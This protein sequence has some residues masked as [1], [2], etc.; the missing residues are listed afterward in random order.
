MIGSGGGGPS[1]CPQ[2]S[3][4]RMQKSPIRYKG[5][6]VCCFQ[7][8]KR[9]LS[10]SMVSLSVETALGSFDFLNNSDWEEEDEENG[11]KDGNGRSVPTEGVRS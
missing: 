4:W 3:T 11:Q 9:S 7:G 6:F 5:V 10:H 2:G 8:R 1:V